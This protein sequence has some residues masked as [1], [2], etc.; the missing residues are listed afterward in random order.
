M[1]KF[2]AIYGPAYVP[3]L[4]GLS[5]Y[6]ALTDAVE[7]TIDSKVVPTGVGA[8]GNLS[9]ND[10]STS[11]S[12]V[13]FGTFNCGLAVVETTPFESN[14]DIFWETSTAGVISELNYDIVT[15]IDEQELF[16]I[17]I[18]RN[19]NGWNEEDESLYW[20]L[21]AALA[22]PAP[23]YNPI[24]FYPTGGQPTPSFD[25]WIISAT[26]K[27]IVG[28]VIPLNRVVGVPSVSVVDNLGNSYTNFIMNNNV[29]QTSEFKLYNLTQQIPYLS[30]PSQG[31]TFTAT[32]TF[33]TLPELPI[34]PNFIKSFDVDFVLENSKPVFITAPQ[35]P[36]RSYTAPGDPNWGQPWPVPSTEANCAPQ[37]TTSDTGIVVGEIPCAGAG[38]NVVGVEPSYGNGMFEQPGFP[39]G[40]NPP[41]DGL[42]F[43]PPWGAP[44]DTNFTG[45]FGRPERASDEI[46]YEITKCVTVELDVPTQTWVPLPITDPNYYDALTKVD[47]V[48]GDNGYFDDPV[49]DGTGSNYNGIEVVS[50]IPQTGTY[51]LEWKVTDA[52]DNDADG[53]ELSIG[54]PDPLIPQTARQ[55]LF[56]IV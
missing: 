10:Q 51:L 20:M 12:N 38:A 16:D 27:N 2:E 7:V 6:L 22:L 28:G 47:W 53:N 37:L 44:E 36:R 54:Y 39:N 55:M 26:P 49:G 33:E 32:I 4:G 34:D 23:P 19:P 52:N 15:N 18:N 11:Y 35:N 3:G 42:P 29:T 41:P 14:I 50:A 43:N 48:Y 45:R 46:K 25:P 17:D 24:D 30:A 9:P 1:K 56:N 5:G 8:A 31:H 21:Q 13:T 40:I